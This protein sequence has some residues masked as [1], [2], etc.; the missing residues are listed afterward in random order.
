MKNI[1]FE[2]V[3]FVGVKNGDVFGREFGFTD[4]EV[5]MAMGKAEEAVGE[6]YGV[7]DVAG[8][9]GEMFASV[10][11]FED[12]DYVITDDADDASGDD[13]PRI[14]T[15]AEAEDLY[16]CF[17]DEWEVVRI[18]GYEYSPSV[19]LKAVDPVAYRCG[20]VD[21]INFLTCDGEYEVEGY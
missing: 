5:V 12:G 7:A 21:Y 8:A 17:L 3:T 13:V 9:L 16:R 4:D 15:E 14:L 20:L 19:A 18:C 10:V 6:D 11:R 1:T 2:N